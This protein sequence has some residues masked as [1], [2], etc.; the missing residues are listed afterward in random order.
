MDSTKIIDTGCD[1]SLSATELLIAVL[2]FLHDRQGMRMVVIGFEE[3]DEEEYIRFTNA[4]SVAEEVGIIQLC[5]KNAKRLADIEDD[6]ELG[7]Q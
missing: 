4:R 7:D 3:S 5:G 6:E 1:P 2:E